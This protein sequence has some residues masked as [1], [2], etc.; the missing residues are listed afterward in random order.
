M[1]KPTKDIHFWPLLLTPLTRQKP[2]NHAAGMEIRV[3]PNEQG[4]AAIP[5]GDIQ[6]TV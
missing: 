4:R 1:I 2:M 3:G 6:S 5:S